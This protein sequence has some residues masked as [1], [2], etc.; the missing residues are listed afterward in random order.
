MEEI[1]GH[2]AIWRFDDETLRI[3]FDSGRKVPR[4]LKLLGQCSLP[5]AAVREVDFDPGDRKRGWSLRLRL[6]DG[7]DPY[8]RA[9]IPV[10]SSPLLLTG[11]HD[12]E[13]LSEYFSERLI[14]SVRYAAGV[15]PDPLDPAEVSRGLV[16]RP[17]LQVR[18]AEGSAS[19]DGERLRLQWDGWL[20]S[21][22]KEREKSREYRFSD[23]ERVSWQP[24]VDLTEGF[25]RVV[26]RGVSLPEAADLENDFFTLVSHG[27]KGADETLLMAVTVNSLLASV[28]NGEKAPAEVEAAPGEAEDGGDGEMIF[29]K[30][31]ELGRLH[32]EGLLTDEEFSTKKAQLLDRL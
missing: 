13:L 29:T 21:T 9:E 31:R 4:L 28:E 8:A 16:G 25:L 22:A 30:I 7:A 15:L 17:P 19:F 27:P 6:M 20:A 3:R 23:I 26:L 2:H 24:T 11:P 10:P 12:R 1:R 14:E 18:T 5:L 32:A